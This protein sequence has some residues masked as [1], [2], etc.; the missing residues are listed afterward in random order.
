MSYENQICELY[1]LLH[2]N[3][4]YE[5]GSRLTLLLRSLKKDS[6]YTDTSSY[7]KTLYCLIGH[8]RDIYFGHGERDIAYMMIHVWYK[9]YPVLAIYAFHQ[10][11]FD[12]KNSLPYG[13]WNDIKYFCKF[14]ARISSHGIYD[15]LIDI[16]ISCANHQLLLD[17]DSYN[18]NRGVSNLCKWIP[19]ENKIEWLFEKLVIHWFS[20]IDL[21]HK[22]CSLSHQKKIYRQM[23][24]SIGKRG[25]YYQVT[26][27]NIF[28]FLSKGNC[29][30]I[31]NDTYEKS[32]SGCSYF[33]DNVFIG[34]YIKTAVSI[35]H[36]KKDNSI[37]IGGDFDSC[38]EAVWLNH[39]WC[40]MVASFF[41]NKCTG[42]I[43][44]IDIS[45]DISDESLY[46]AIGFAC[47]LAI[48][49]GLFRILLVSNTPIWIEFT[50]TD[51]ICSIVNK[52]WCFCGCR[53]GSQFSV[54][55]QFLMNG[56]SK[57]ILHEPITPLKIFNGMPSDVPLEIQGQQLS[58][59]ELNGP[60]PKGVCPISNLHQCNLF[61]FSHRFLFDWTQIKSN[62]SIVFWNIGNDICHLKPGFHIDDHKEILFVS[63]FNTALF[64]KFCSDVTVTGGSYEFLLASLH[65]YRY[66]SLSDYFDS[67]TSTA[68]PNTVSGISSATSS[69]N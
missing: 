55:F 68:S 19:R 33:H 21:L 58:I 66:K 51:S 16:A 10:F 28:Q 29:K 57:N 48:K 69:S 47:L 11:V 25:G 61:I 49:S 46:H 4:I 8:V 20:Q 3:N 43:P 30:C 32:K 7:L 35:I 39:K 24:V 50:N 18:C 42:G 40:Q 2:R 15:P 52:I 36:K 14:I 13:C 26:I 64:A 37:F 67:Q 27:K 12:N 34:T 17:L 56:F 63:G 54:S 1:F 62:Y 5:I 38:T 44:L 6:K 41:D 31:V 60:P 9:F 45:A 22:D 65:S 59:N 53:T 23:I